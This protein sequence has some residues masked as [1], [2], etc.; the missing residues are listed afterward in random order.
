MRKIVIWAA[1]LLLGASTFPASS[2]KK[3]VLDGKQVFEQHCASCHAGGGNRVEPHRPVAGSKQLV[4][5]AIFKSYLS[6]PPGHMPYYADVVNDQATLKALYD[7]CR[8]LKAPP[9]K[10]AAADIPPLL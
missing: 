5:L 1:I 9:A 7:Y 2:A 3:N 6:E 10:E 4:T 8:S